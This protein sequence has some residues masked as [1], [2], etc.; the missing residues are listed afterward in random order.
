M[1]ALGNRAQ[2]LALPAI[3]EDARIEDEHDLTDGG[4]PTPTY[5]VFRNRIAELRLFRALQQW[6]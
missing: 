1:A 3:A 6:A 2:Q 4:G 5:A